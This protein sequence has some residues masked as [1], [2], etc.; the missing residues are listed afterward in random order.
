MKISRPERIARI[1]WRLA[2]NPSQSFSLSDIA[3]EFEVS[4][5]VLSD[6]VEI[7]SNAMNDE[8]YSRIIIDRGRG[9]GIFN[10]LL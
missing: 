7:I 2:K 4:K 1:V 8:G 3:K 5:T 10:S 6:D 9:R